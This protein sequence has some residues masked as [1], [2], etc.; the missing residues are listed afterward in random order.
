MARALW[1]WRV[2]PLFSSP[3]YYL[4]PSAGPG[5]R[6]MR[7]TYRQR[8]QRHLGLGLPPV[9]RNFGPQ[10]ALFRKKSKSA[11]SRGG[12]WPPAIPVVV[13]SARLT[14]VCRCVAFFIA[15]LRCA[16]SR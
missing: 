5:P 6:P 4:R 14:Y 7:E 11:P 12:C 15:F 10:N 13:V 9:N 1:T 8:F 16:L 3:P 2:A